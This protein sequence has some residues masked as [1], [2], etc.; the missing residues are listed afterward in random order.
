MNPYRCATVG[1]ERSGG[2]GIGTSRLRSIAFCGT[3]WGGTREGHPY[4][5]WVPMR[6]DQ[7]PPLRES[8][9]V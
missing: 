8:E 6:A 9:Q 7:G 3:G 1:G 4:G 5:I 2:V